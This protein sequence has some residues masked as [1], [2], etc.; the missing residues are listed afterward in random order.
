MKK[1]ISSKLKENNFSRESGGNSQQ[2]QQA[3]GKYLIGI[4]DGRI[5]LRM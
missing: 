2:E 5:F 3:K 1:K 4:Y